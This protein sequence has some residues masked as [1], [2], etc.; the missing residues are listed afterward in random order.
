MFEYPPGQ[1]LVGTLMRFHTGSHEMMNRVWAVV[2]SDAA[3]EN[4]PEGVVELETEDIRY[5]IRP[6]RARVIV[7]YI[8]RH[9]EVIFC[10]RGHP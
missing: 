9:A 8:L 5:P 2:Q 3:S 4:K 10:P 6:P 7:P 1:F